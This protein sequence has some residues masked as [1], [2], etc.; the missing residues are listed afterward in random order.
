M[1]KFVACNLLGLMFGLAF[2]CIGQSEFPQVKEAVMPFYPQ[3]PSGAREAGEVRIEITIGRSG[4]VVKA[5]AIA[6]PERLRPNSEAAARKWRFESRKGQS[7]AHIIIVTFA[8]ILRPEVTDN[9][10]VS[11]IF[12][13]P[14]RVEV[15]AD[16]RQ[17]TRI[18]DPGFEDVDKG[19][20]K[21][22]ERQ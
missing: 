16:N 17:V 19:R 11:G 22:T 14:N 13:P 2:H 1:K 9:S 8:Y 4:E 21:K 7:A 5:K 10:K 6:G 20:K 18:A 12:E 15:F 3:L